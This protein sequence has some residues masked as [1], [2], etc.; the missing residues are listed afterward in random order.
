MFKKSIFKI[1]LLTL[2]ICLTAGCMNNNGNGSESDNVAV[3]ENNSKN[4]DVET[5]KYDISSETYK[6][7]NI[8]IEYPQFKTKDGSDDDAINSWNKL[9]KDSLLNVA[10]TI[11]NGVQSSDFKLDMNYKVKTN[12]NKI[13][14]VIFPLNCSYK[15]KQIASCTAFNLDVSKGTKMD[16]SEDP[17]F[18]EYVENIFNDKN[19]SLKNKEEKMIT[20]EDELKKIKEVI[21]KDLKETGIVGLRES[22][23]R[24]PFYYEDGKTIIMIP[25]DS[26]NL[27]Y[28]LAVM[29]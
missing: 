21:Y 22:L 6:E 12:N 5:T 9:L 20:D 23:K 17:N 14:S 3:E 15:G 28:V 7:G 25:T 11:K 27:D 29:E 1:G 2:G 10:N 13:I 16:L 8:S 24:M 18:S 26:K 4:D 19:Y